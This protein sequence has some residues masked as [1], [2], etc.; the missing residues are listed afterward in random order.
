MP[1]KYD[2]RIQSDRVVY[3]LHNRCPVI[4]STPLCLEIP[5]HKFH[6]LTLVPVERGGKGDARHDVT[7]RSL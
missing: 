6:P 7:Y 2:G 1:P 5:Q 3:I 4:I